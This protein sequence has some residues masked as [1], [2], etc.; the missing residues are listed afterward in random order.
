MHDP[1]SEVGDWLKRVV[2]GY[3][4]YHAVPGNS[5][6]MRTFREDL[7]RNWYKVLRHRG[8]KRRIN[9]QAFSPIVRFWI[10]TLKV[11]HPHP[12]ERFYAKHPR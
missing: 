2:L 11:M 4:R 10:P 1:I 7:I 9:W 5:E 6:A 3:D 12:N 8:Q